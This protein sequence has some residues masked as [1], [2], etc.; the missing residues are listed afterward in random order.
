MS[1][2][3]RMA[4][5]AL[6]AHQRA[7]RAK[8]PL[9]EGATPDGTWETLAPEYRERHLDTMRA[10]LSVIVEPSDGMM[11]ARTSQSDEPWW[12]EDALARDFTAMI[13]HALNGGS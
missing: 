6:E 11:G 8:F 4:K 9:P 3:E 2:L 12:Y 7:F 10:A 1:V 5:A 13:E